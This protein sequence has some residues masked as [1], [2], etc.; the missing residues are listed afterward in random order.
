MISG[1]ADVDLGEKVILIIESEPYTFD[2]EIFNE[3]E[4]Y[5][6]PKEIFFLKH[7]KDSNN[8]KLLR[9]ETLLLL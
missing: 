2:K 9:K 8:G 4:K 6:K 5:E 1:K 7:F 3:L